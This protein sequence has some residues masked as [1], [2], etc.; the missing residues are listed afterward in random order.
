MCPLGTTANISGAPTKGSELSIAP[1]NTETAEP[2]CS[3]GP[4]KLGTQLG[5]KI[6]I[7]Q[8]EFSLALTSPQHALGIG[9]RT[10]VVQKLPTSGQI[11]QRQKRSWHFH[12]KGGSYENLPVPA[13][14]PQ[15]QG[16][17]S[18][19]LVAL[20]LVQHLLERAEVRSVAFALVQ[21]KLQALHLL[22]LHRNLL[23]H[24]VP[25]LAHQRQRVLG[26]PD[27]GR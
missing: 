24:L 2:Q 18:H 13:S 15:P 14:H 17:L 5:L 10:Q 19:Q 9:R 20:T 8:V 22:L 16:H 21:S 4:Q 11:R 6:C 27:R 1:F 3:I 12:S 7:L 26:M 23:L 25:P